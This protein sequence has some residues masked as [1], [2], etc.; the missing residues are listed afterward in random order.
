MSGSVTPN[1]QHADSSLL[2]R[3]RK[4]E[5][6]F[7]MAE[8]SREEGE[9][10][11]SHS[12]DNNKKTSEIIEMGEVER[13]IPNFKENKRR[14]TPLNYSFYD[15]ILKEGFIHKIAA[16]SGQSKWWGG[17]PIWITS[18]RQGKKS[19]VI[20]WPGSNVKIN[21]V[22]PD[23]H[24]PYARVTTAQDKMDIALN[25]LDMPI[26]QRPQSISIYIPQ[27]DQKGHGGGPDGKQL[28]SV[29]TDMDNAIGHL[30]KGLEQRNLDSHVHVVLVSDHGMAA[31]DKS[32]LIFYDD[33]ISPES[34][35]YLHPREAW[36]LLGL[37]PREDAPEYILDQI[38][39]EIEEYTRSHPNPRFQFYRREEIPTRFHYNSTERIAP[40][41]MIPDVG[42]AIVRSTDKKLPPNGIH[43][44]DNLALEMR[45]IFAA[46]GPKVQQNYESGATLKPF[47]NI[48]VYKFLTTLLN[49]ESAP[50]NSTLNGN[51]ESK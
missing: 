16:I 47:F 18:K 48:E 46:R 22:S 40:I 19:A 38:Y 45:A 8:K 31:F 51:F 24:I 17:E 14:W 34:E 2:L 41:V 43:G 10:Y 25:W 37:R 30:M 39:S 27:I 12:G 1:S 42:H 23:Y 36:P 20:M 21:G 5:R 9:S 3:T 7:D 49:L 28:N 11:K 26:D 35:S 33:I 13:W 44:Y 4:N 32:K 6:E 15:P 29:L 50:N